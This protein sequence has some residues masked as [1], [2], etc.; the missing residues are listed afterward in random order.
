MAAN[1]SVLDL[2]RVPLTTAEE[3]DRLQQRQLNRM[4]DL[5]LQGW[6]PKHGWLVPPQPLT[7]C[8]ECDREFQDRWNERIC[9]TCWARDNK[10]S[11]L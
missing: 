4:A 9:R 5:Q 10:E 6:E 7:R 3:A 8:T 2:P 11:D 1:A